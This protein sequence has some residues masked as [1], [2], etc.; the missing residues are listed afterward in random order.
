MNAAPLKPEMRATVFLAPD[1][2]L[3]RCRSVPVFCQAPARA[4]VGKQIHLEHAAAAAGAEQC[5]LLLEAVLLDDIERAPVQRFRQ[6]FLDNKHAVWWDQPVVK[7]IPGPPQK[8]P[9]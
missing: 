2:R 4:L 5:G 3:K 8:T 9:P 6:V 7:A 1:R